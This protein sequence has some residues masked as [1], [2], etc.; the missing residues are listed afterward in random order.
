[1][2][3]TPFKIKAAARPDTCNQAKGALVVENPNNKLSVRWEDNSS[4]LSRTGLLAG[5]YSVKVFSNLVAGCEQDT[6][7]EVLNSNLT[8][9]VDTTLNR[10]TPCYDSTGMARVVMKNYP[11][12]SFLYNWQNKGFAKIDSITN[13]LSNTYN[14]VIL[15]DVSKCSTQTS[16]FVPV[17]PFSVQKASRP[18]L[19]KNANGQVEVILPSNKIQLVWEDVLQDNQLVRNNLTEGTYSFRAFST[20]NAGFDCSV[21]ESILVV[22][23]DHKVVFDT[24]ITQNPTCANPSGKGEIYVNPFSPTTEYE[25][26]WQDL[27]GSPNSQFKR[28]NLSVGEYFATVYEKGTLCKA[29]TSFELVAEGFDF[30]LD[31]KPTICTSNRGE[32]NVTVLEGDENVNIRWDDISESVY[33]RQNLPSGTYYFTLVSDFDPSCSVDTFA[34]V[35]QL[36]NVL[37]ADFEIEY[38]RPLD[39]VFLEDTLKFIN[40]SPVSTPIVDWKFDDGSSGA[41][42]PYYYAYKTAGEH[43]TTLYIEDEYGCHATARRPVTLLEFKDCGVAM[44]NAFTPNEDGI[45]DKIGLLGFADQIELRI[46]TRWGEMIYRSFDLKERWDGTFKEGESPVDTYVYQLDYVCKPLRGPVEKKYVMGEITLI[47]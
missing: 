29:D 43:Y 37:T 16:V 4:N 5:A 42:S 6:S 31:Q 27:G 47:R 34:V 30:R 22:N 11:N 21:R 38:G 26:V 12:T 10:A 32:V 17:L 45:N 14:V 7:L 9:E 19:C 20:L 36:N 41:G 28:D 2:P 39:Q 23:E 25:I 15:D 18:E 33:T 46:Y 35:D 24:L 8:F 44:P 13:L 40:T 1:V 3:Q